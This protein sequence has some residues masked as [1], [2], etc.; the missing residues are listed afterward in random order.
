MKT[1]IQGTF[2][3]MNNYGRIT[4][5]LLLR[6][7]FNN[8]SSIYE[9]GAFDEYLN[10]FTAEPALAFDKFF[11]QEVKFIYKHLNC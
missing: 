10:G 1:L 2:D 7:L 3:L 6:H 11:S 4:K 5:R 8:P 9:H